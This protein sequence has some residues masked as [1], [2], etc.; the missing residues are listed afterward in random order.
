MQPSTQVT[1]IPEACTIESSVLFFVNVAADALI[2]DNDIGYAPFP[3]SIL[4][5]LTSHAGGHVTHHIFI[6][7]LLETRRA[8]VSTAS[9]DR[10]L[11]FVIGA[12]ELTG[13]ADVD[14]GPASPAVL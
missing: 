5:D 9:A 6:P 2:R 11:P 1:H 8:E 3:F 4:F 14:A 12:A 7:F 10:A 13:R